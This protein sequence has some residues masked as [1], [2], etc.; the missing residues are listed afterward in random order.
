MKEDAA[1]SAA[2]SPERLKDFLQIKWLTQRWQLYALFF[3]RQ[4]KQQH[5]LTL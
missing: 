1:A 5:F 2:F 4:K 3:P